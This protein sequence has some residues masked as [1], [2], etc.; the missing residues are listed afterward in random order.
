MKRGDKVF[1][2]DPDSSVH[3]EQ[4]AVDKVGE[5]SA[6]VTCKA[7][8]RLFGWWPFS[9]LSTTPPTEPGKHENYVEKM[10]RRRE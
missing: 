6:L 7:W 10:K 4:F 8:P 1:L 9:K 2:N 5:E 3:G